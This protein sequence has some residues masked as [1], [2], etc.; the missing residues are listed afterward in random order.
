MKLYTLDRK[1]TLSEGLE[2]SLFQF[3]DIQPPE[4]QTH[5]NGILPNGVTKHGDQ[6]FASGLQ[7]N[8]LGNGI[9]ELVFEYVRRAH[10]P[11]KPSRLQSLFACDNLEDL[12]SFNQNYNTPGKEFS[13]WTL[14]T[15]NFF[16][17]DLKLLTFSPT[18]LGV[19]YSRWPRLNS[20]GY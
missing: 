12:K 15:E 14:E 19:S 18:A 17:G 9:L 20:F 16:R 11:D 6:Y 1:N 13:I 10:Y 5:L 3:S 8:N 2:I 7:S 4:L